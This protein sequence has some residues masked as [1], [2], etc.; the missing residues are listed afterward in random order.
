MI[1][2]HSALIQIQL[3][4]P[5]LYCQESEEFF[6]KTL[7]WF[8]EYHKENVQLSNKLVF[9]SMTPFQ[10]KLWR[11]VLLQKK[12]LYTCKNIVTKPKRNSYARFLNNIA[13]KIVANNIKYVWQLTGFFFYPSI[14]FIF[15]VICFVT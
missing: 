15:I 3:N 4:T 2:V 8:N 7:R 14:P 13:F 10:C 12:Y 9:F 1:N 6:S 5:F 11:L